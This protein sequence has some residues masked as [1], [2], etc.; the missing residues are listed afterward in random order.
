MKARVLTFSLFLIFFS[1]FFLGNIEKLNCGNTSNNVV[2]INTSTELFSLTNGIIQEYQK[3]LLN[4]KFIVNK[5]THSADLYPDA[6]SLSLINDS[7]L[8]IVDNQSFRCVVVGRDIVV[9]V[10][11]TKNPYFDELVRHGVTIQ[12]LKNTLSATMNWDNL[13]N[14]TTA[15]KQVSVYMVKDRS[16]S[17]ILSNWL[18][19]KEPIIGLTNCLELTEMIQ[20]LQHEPM[21]LAFCKLSQIIQ[22]DGEQWL[23]GIA[24]LP[25]DKNANGK[26]DYVESFYDN[27]QAFS[28]SVWI[29]KYPRELTSSVYVVSS[30]NPQ[31]ESEITF[32][33]WL[34]TNGQCAITKC[35]LTSLNYNEQ[36]VQLTRINEPQQ[37]NNIPSKQATTLM[38]ALLLVLIVIVLSGV[39][40]ELI[41]RVL[42]RKTKKENVTVENVTAFTEEVINVPMGF[43]F[44][45]SHSWAFMRK[46]GTIKVG[47]DDFLQ[48]V[49]GKIT[50][51]EVKEMGVK[52]R[53]GDLLCSISRRGK[54]L[55]VYS[56]ITGT[57]KD[58][59]QSLKLNSALLNS[60]PYF[61]GWIYVI[62][63]VNWELELQYLQFAN[64][65]KDNLKN[66]FLRLKDFINSGLK[67][68]SSDYAYP[69]LQDGGS[70]IDHPL[71]EL[72]P[73]IW[74]DFQTKFIDAAK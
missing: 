51:V 20:K 40:I 69:I 30:L 29:G 65:F 21:S 45:K 41:F 56:P 10:I 44:D 55:H 50:K 28:R 72:G 2:K 71:A 47:I 67:V 27:L 17:S 23:N 73:D 4:Q 3:G 39:C 36:L 14:D 66:E 11:S 59:N 12:K 64:K 57:I 62:E 32:L 52:I 63:P 58:V 34:V 8:K 15:K 31:L 35:G 60:D 43:Y 9:P 46:N 5:I 49:T 61:E 22:P 7:L 13:L 70:L 6:G 74:D 1:V 18:E 37:L 26:I 25:I 53:K 68:V 33:K 24:I 16:V 42:F 48:H 54:T 19:K 38:S